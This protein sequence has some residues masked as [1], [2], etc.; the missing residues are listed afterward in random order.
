MVKIGIFTVS[1]CRE[2]LDFAYENRSSMKSKNSRILVI[3]ELTLEK[4]DV[5][6]TYIKKIRYVIRY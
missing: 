4:N 1:N 6:M 2:F 3:W 5:S